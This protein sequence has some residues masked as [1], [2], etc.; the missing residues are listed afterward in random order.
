MVSSEESFLLK[1]YVTSLSVSL[2]PFLL[3]FVNLT[4]DLFYKNQYDWQINF[5]G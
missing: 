5:T 4:G 1:L 3:K 2:R